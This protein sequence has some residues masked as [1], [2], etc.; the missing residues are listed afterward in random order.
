M[1]LFLEI[2]ANL[3]TYDALL[4]REHDASLMVR[5]TDGAHWNYYNYFR[6][7][8]PLATSEQSFIQ[9]KNDFV[10]LGVYENSSFAVLL[11][12]ILAIAPKKIQQVR[13][14]R[15]RSLVLLPKTN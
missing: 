7:T 13:H 10:I 5:A 4:R 1:N 15:F 6:K 11:D 14:Q 9:H 3:E 12:T 8:A 2:G